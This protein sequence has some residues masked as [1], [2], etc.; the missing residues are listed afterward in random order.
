M[1]DLKT[2]TLSGADSLTIDRKEVLRY[3]RYTNNQIDRGVANLIDSVE[4]EVMSLSRPKAVY[5]ESSVELSGSNIVKL[6]FLEIKS[7]NLFIFLKE[8]K[9]VIMF[10]ATIGIEIDRKI[11]KYSA[12]NQLKSTIYHSV[13]SALVE[14]FCDYVSKVVTNKKTILK[15]YS[16]GYGDLSL[17]YQRPILNILDANKKVGIS[18]NDS[19]IMSP[20]KSVT[21][22]IGL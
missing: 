5:C 20:S 15:R 12:I 13:G 8:C 10:A 22:F 18:L 17:E 1:S 2:I 9:K 16:P 21:A 14:S 7:K 11:E 4:K 19:Y 6:E 3:L